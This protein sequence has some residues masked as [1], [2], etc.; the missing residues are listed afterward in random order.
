M[1]KINNKNLNFKIPDNKY[2][3]RLS[4]Q[5]A[6]SKKPDLCALGGI[7]MCWQVG[8]ERFQVI[9]RKKDKRKS[10]A[11]AFSE[12]IKYNYILRAIVGETLCKPEQPASIDMILR[13]FQR[14]LYETAPE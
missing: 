10:N 1:M 6:C 3:I 11:I 7:I 9:M 5:R 4:N 12:D 2:T 14:F 13:L 8:Y